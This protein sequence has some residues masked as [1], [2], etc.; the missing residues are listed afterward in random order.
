MFSISFSA[1]PSYNDV[2]HSSS[3]YLNKQRE[4][5]YPL[6]PNDIKESS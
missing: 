5:P 4:I 6:S 2:I 3:E 1:P